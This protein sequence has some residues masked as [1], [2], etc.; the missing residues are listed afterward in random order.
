MKMGSGKM[1]D[2]YICMGQKPGKELYM[3]EGFAVES[4]YQGYVFLGWA[5]GQ[6]ETEAKEEAGL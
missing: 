6:F 1:S 5:A 3:G 4:S 2:S